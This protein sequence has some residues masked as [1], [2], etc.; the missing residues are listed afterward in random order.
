ML[1]VDEIKDAKK[2]VDQK[3]PL[4]DIPIWKTLPFLKGLKDFFPEW[5]PKTQKA[6]IEKLKKAYTQRKI[7]AIA[8]G[9]EIAAY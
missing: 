5:V 8:S 2:L 1:T 4:S 6:E 7:M 3:H 9:S